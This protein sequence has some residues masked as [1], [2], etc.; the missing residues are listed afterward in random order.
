MKSY[1]IYLRI[2]VSSTEY[3]PGC[4]GIIT[5]CVSGAKH[6]PVENNTLIHFDSHPDMLIPQD[7]TSEESLDKYKLF[8]KLSI[9]NWILPGVYMGV[10]RTIVWVCPWWCN[11]IQPG[12]YSFH[13]GRNKKTNL[14]QSNFPMDERVLSFATCLSTTSM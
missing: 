2:S 11:Q 1:L 7:L 14:L 4:I 3:W 8:E 13:V 10:L 5:V 9:E 6:L 12:D